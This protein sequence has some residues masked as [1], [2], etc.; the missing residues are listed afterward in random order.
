MIL[1]SQ[2]DKPYSPDGLSEMLDL[3]IKAAGLPD[4]CVPHGLRKAAARRLAEA[5]CTVKQIASI[6]G[7]KS[8]SEVERYTKK[9]EQKLMAR[10]AVTRLEDHSRRRKTSS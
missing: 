5:G 1:S 2:Y 7:H 3:A 6:T 8:L 4:R 10:D 9:A